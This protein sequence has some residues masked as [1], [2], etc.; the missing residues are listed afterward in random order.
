MK[1]IE[2]LT[3]RGWIELDYNK[4]FKK[5][6]K[7]GDVLISS[8]MYMFDGYGDS[9]SINIRTLDSIKEEDFTILNVNGFCVQTKVVDDYDD[10]NGW[11]EPEGRIFVKKKE[12]KY[13][14]VEIPD[15]MLDKAKLLIGARVKK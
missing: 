13:I 10:N 1:T 9:D 3:K 12:A 14:T 15:F 8:S 6:I 11:F 4:S 5:Q 7:K 2:E